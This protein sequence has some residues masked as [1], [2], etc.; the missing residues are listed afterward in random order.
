MCV[1]KI[2]MKFATIEK[3]LVCIGNICF[4][5]IAYYSGFLWFFPTVVCSYKWN[6]TFLS[7]CIANAMLRNYLRF[8]VEILTRFCFWLLRIRVKG[9]VCVTH[10]LIIIFTKHTHTHT[11]RF[12]HIPENVEV[13]TNASKNSER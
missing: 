5:S 12:L 8:S 9:S 7:V 1:W 4:T 2:Q 3:C 11:Q 10:L 6:E 13:K